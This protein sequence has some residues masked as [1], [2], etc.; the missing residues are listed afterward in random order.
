[1]PVFLQEDEL[2]EKY[3]RFKS[4][5]RTK[6]VRGGFEMPSNTIPDQYNKEHRFQNS[7]MPLWLQHN[8]STWFVVQLRFLKPCV[9]RPPNYRVFNK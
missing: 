7:M 4:T 9:I 3:F 6:R 1:M 2:P 5:S 8:S